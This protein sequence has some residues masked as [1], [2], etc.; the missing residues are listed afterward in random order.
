MPILNINGK[1]FEVNEFYQP[2]YKASPP[3]SA[4]NC[5]D[6]LNTI[7]QAEYGYNFNKMFE[8]DITDWGCNL[9]FFTFNLAEHT[10]C[11]VFG[12]DND[13]RN[14]DV[15][16]FLQ[17]VYGT[18]NVAFSPYS[19]PLYKPNTKSHIILSF[20][21]HQ[22]Y[23]PEIPQNILEIF[24]ESETIYLELAHYLEYPVWAEN[25][26]PEVKIN[27]FLYWLQK[28]KEQ[29]PDFSI[30]LIGV[31]PTHLG[32]VRPLFQCKRK[33]NEVLQIKSEKFGEIEGIVWDRFR[34]PYLDFND[35]QWEKEKKS[36]NIDL[37]KKENTHYAYL[38]RN[39]KDYFLKFKNDQ[40]VTFTPFIDGLLL[41]DLI[42]FGMLPYYDRSFIKQQ[43]SKILQEKTLN[44]PQ[45]WNFIIDSNSLLYSIDS[46]Q[47]DDK[48]LYCEKCRPISLQMLMATI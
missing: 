21:H 11:K 34:L 39:N 40:L 24:N 30:R 31:H 42:K 35:H 43:L 14:I 27:P 48:S 3:N 18:K 8:S 23:K 7:L 4:R 46:E 25:L 16:L 13:I 6:R 47:E 2:L 1:N 44:D 20:L 17:K 41:S 9:G 33:L 37:R 36:L 29:L 15:C 12:I 19:I 32:S 28:L 38:N 22:Q 45:S 26:I 5:E 10:K